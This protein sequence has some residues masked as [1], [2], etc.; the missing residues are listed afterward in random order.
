MLQG[1]QMQERSEFF[2][3][4]KSNYIWWNRIESPEKDPQVYIHLIYD[5]GTTEWCGKEGPSNKWCR[6]N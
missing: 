5:E 6:V 4:P 2:I 1:T 3:F